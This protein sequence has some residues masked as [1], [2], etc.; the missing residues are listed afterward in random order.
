MINRDEW[1]HGFVLPLVAG[2]DVRVRGA[3]GA[4]ELKQLLDG[5]IDGEPAA[6]AVGEARLAIGAELWIDAE[7]PLLDEASL[8]LAVAV[9][10]LLFLAHP[11]AQSLPVTKSR[12]KQVA[13]YA[14]QCAS[15][16]EARDLSELVARHSMIHHLF[17]LGRDDVRVSFWA[18]RREYRGAE[19][20]GRLLKWPHLRRVRE[21]RWRVGVVAEAIAETHQREIVMALCTASPLTDLLEPT[22]LEPRFDLKPVVKYLGEPRVARAVAERWLSMGLEQ[23]GPAFSSALIDL[24]NQKD[25]QKE[26]R[27]ATRFLCH[28][29]LLW[30]LGELGTS[31]ATRR[32]RVFTMAAHKEAI[33]D[34]FGLFAAA[35][36]VGL[37][38]PTDVANDP[39]LSVVVDNHAAHTTA[40]CGTS[41]ILELVE[42][43]SRGVGELALAS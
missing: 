3:L 21:E 28:L 12:R 42:L 7:A 19:P 27:L 41:R 16:P 20:P 30:L 43:M 34:F 6:E 10:N 8:R 36:R 37:G 40:L 1:L 22:R 33:K 38:R 26:A 4:V 25:A 11:D 13:Q 9:Q 2:G 32:T 24:Y 31:E 14:T 18:G 29:Q 23:I 35:Q 5:T 17:D 15:L 39:R